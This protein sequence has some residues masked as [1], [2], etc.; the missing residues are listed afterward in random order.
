MEDKQ[1]LFE[2]TYNITKSDLTKADKK[3]FTKIYF[4]KCLIPIIVLIIVL[5]LLFISIFTELLP[6]PSHIIFGGLGGGAIGYMLLELS[7]FI[8]SFKQD[9]KRMEDIEISFKIYKDDIDF[10]IKNKDLKHTTR[11]AKYDN[12]KG[13]SSD[14]NYHYLFF[15]I[16]TNEFVIIKNTEEK[17][18]NQLVKKIKTYKHMPI[19][20]IKRQKRYFK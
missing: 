2:S 11:N 20:I 1:I 3:F 12:I 15:S 8:V 16:Y 5:P 10:T 4:K 14:K 19:K 7:S 17:L 9:K 13:I 18:Y 6:Y